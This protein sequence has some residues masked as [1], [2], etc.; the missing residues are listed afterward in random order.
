[1]AFQVSSF[2]VIILLFQIY[3]LFLSFRLIQNVHTYTTYGLSTDHLYSLK[4]QIFLL[5]F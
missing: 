4:I 5:I 3:G 2:N 1:M